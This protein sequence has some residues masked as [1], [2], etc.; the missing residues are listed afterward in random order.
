M[1][2]KDLANLLN[3]G[4]ATITRYEI[5]LTYP[6]LAQIDKIGEIF[7]INPT[8]LYD[9]Y[10]LF[11]INFKDEI[12]ELLNLY[13][14]QDIAYKTG[15]NNLRTINDWLKGYHMPNTKVTK[16]LIELKKAAC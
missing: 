11:T 14:K 1:N 2:K 6:T 12:N 5:G 15:I 9:E 16:K 10:I 4:N 3:C 13:S 7:N 8:T